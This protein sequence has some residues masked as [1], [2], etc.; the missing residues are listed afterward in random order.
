M[1]QGD[2]SMSKTT[3]M[4]FGMIGL[5]GF[6]ITSIESGGGI[7]GLIGLAAIVLALVLNSLIDDVEADEWQKKVEDAK[8]R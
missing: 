4:I 7:G 2:N 5:V 8:R 6:G 3:M 1:Q